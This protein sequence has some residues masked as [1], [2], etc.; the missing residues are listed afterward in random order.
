MKLIEGGIYSSKKHQD[1]CIIY[2]EK[3]MDIF[4]ACC[5]IKIKNSQFSL[6]N[7]QQKLKCNIN[8]F[9]TIARKNEKEI[10]EM[11]D[12]YFG[13]LDENLCQELKKKIL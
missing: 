1:M 13:K 11:V 8:N 5:L 10:E 9:T 12:G 3:R 7:I 6:N 2:I 4:I